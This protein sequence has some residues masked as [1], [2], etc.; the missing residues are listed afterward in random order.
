MLDF[1]G[2]YNSYFKDKTIAP[3]KLVKSMVSL[4]K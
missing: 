1:A 2:Q 3:F 4:S